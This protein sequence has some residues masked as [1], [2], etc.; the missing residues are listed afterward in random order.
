MPEFNV[1]SGGCTVEV[2]VSPT[3][4]HW[5]HWVKNLGSPFDYVR[6][7]KKTVKESKKLGVEKLYFFIDPEDVPLILL[8]DRAGAKTEK[9]V[10]SYEV[11]S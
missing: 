2:K 8:Y 9:V 10:M 3:G 7:L 6:A 5:V 4:E 11:K 1:E